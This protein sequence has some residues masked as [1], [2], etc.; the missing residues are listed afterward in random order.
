MNALY[1]GVYFPILPMLAASGTAHAVI[2]GG[3]LGTGTNNG[4]ESGLQSYLS[5]TSQASFNHWNNLVRVNDA[6]GV[7]LGY[8]QSTGNG[9]VLGAT[10]VGNPGTI[11]VAGTSYAVVHS[12]TVTGTDLL[13]MEISGV[14]ETAAESLPT[15]DLASTS[16]AANEFVLVTGRGYTSASGPSDPYPWGPTNPSDSQVM[17]WGTNRVDTVQSA[18]VGPTT[19]MNIITDFDPPGDTAGAGAVT[20]YEAQVAVGDSGGGMFS[21]RA[22]RWV[23]VGI[24]HFAD[25]EGGS[26][27]ESAEYGDRSGYSD[28]FTYRTG[29][30]TITGALIPEPSSALLLPLAGAVLWLRRRM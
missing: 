17:R 8:N 25:D 2:V 10:H 9:W 11:T 24:G 4:S 1:R 20:P 29:I 23:L 27:A 28:I 15:V 18:V 13:L 16:A 6:S 21:Y 12:Q 5:S 22:G 7:Y 3:T 19:S 26:A 14:T 30:T